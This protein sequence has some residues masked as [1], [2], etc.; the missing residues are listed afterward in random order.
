[1]TC[2]P[3]AAKTG[4]PWG[5]AISIPSWNLPLRGPNRE[6]TSPSTGHANTRL[7]RDQP[8]SG[9]KGLRAGR[10]SGRA[11]ATD[12]AVE[13]GLVTVRQTDQIDVALKISGLRFQVL[14]HPLELQ[15]EG[16][17]RLRQQ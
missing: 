17:H 7:S 5:A 1:M 15:V 11:K 16:F 14:H 3:A 8:P 10:G 9:C 6:L 2:P 4:V 12:R 13:E